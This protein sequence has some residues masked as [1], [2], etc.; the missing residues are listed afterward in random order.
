VQLSHW[1]VIA[2]V[3]LP[4]RTAKL[5]FK[6]KIG[7]LREDRI[8][9]RLAFWRSVVGMVA[10]MVATYGYQ[11]VIF[12]SGDM[13]LKVMQTGA[14]ALL[15]PPLSFLVI[16]IVT[17]PGRR[18]QLIPGARRLL[19][20][21]ALALTF[22]FLPF[23]LMNLAGDQININIPDPGGLIVFIP[24][25]PLV[26]V[27]CFCFWCCTVYWAARTGLWT[28][29]IHPLL[30]P[31]G[32]TVLM[33]LINGQ[34]IIDGDTDG[35]P[36]WLW[37]TLNLCGTTTSLVLCVLEYRHLRSIGYQFRSGPEPVTRSEPEPVH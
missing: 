22:F 29:E 27:W 15:L 6:P 7:P 24:A 9:D 3:L 5:V 4:W 18:S 30:A 25:I 26:I 10:I 32:T 17:R 2:T 14:Y 33:L 16:L 28:G 19:G 23:F 34:E 20:R 11:D 8:L 36:H 21:V 13:F 31:I 12:V 35:V 37:L 1:R